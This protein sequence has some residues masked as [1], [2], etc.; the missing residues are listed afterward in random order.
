MSPHGVMLRTLDSESNDRG[1]D[2]REAVQ[3][4]IGNPIASA[5]RALQMQQ[6][7]RDDAR[8]YGD[9]PNGRLL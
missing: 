6:Q 8:C 7:E 3:N 1:A 2:P 9:H 5:L 4:A